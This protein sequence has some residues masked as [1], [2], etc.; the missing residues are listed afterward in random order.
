MGLANQILQAAVRF[1]P[2]GQT[3]AQ[4]MLA[5]LL[6]LFTSLAAEAAT[7]PLG[8]IGSTTPGADL[9]QMRHE[10]LPTRIFRT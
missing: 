10:T 2:M 7:T 9:A 1:L 8:A 3:E 6:P 5:R 4:A